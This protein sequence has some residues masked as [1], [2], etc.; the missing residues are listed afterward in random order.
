MTDEE[1]FVSWAHEPNGIRVMIANSVPPPQNAPVRAMPAGM[2]SQSTAAGR[3]TLAHILPRHPSG[4]ARCAQSWLARNGRHVAAI[5]E[6]RSSL[7]GHLSA[8]G[9]QRTA[10]SLATCC[11]QLQGMASS[12][13]ARPDLGVASVWM[14]SSILDAV[15]LVLDL[16]SSAINSS[17]LVF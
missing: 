9:S 4:I 15:R 10:V 14:A 3:S 17:Q 5:P 8:Q 1:N 12:P 16:M 13:Q 6:N 2:G 7:S 11:D